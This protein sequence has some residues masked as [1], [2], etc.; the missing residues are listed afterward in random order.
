MHCLN[1]SEFAQHPAT[2]TSKAVFQA[3][4]TGSAIAQLPG[5][6][7]SRIHIDMLH[8]V[9][10]GVGADAVASAGARVN[11]GLWSVDCLSG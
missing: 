2:F 5:F 10:L 1:T 4:H 6:D 3:C 11:L 8:V 7:H 9:D